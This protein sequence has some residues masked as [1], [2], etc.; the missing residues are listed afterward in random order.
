MRGPMR[1]HA[2][3]HTP[4][5]SR[6]SRPNHKSRPTHAEKNARVGIFVQT[7]R[8]AERRMRWFHLLHASLGFYGLAP[9]AARDLWSGGHQRLESD[10]YT[11][12]SILL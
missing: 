3:P 12:K 4:H 6:P 2:E 9:C 5:N 7:D 1:G 10:P 8:K 11:Q